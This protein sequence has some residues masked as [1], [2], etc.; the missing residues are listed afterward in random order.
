MGLGPDVILNRQQAERSSRTDFTDESRPNS[1]VARQT[2]VPNDSQMKAA[3]YRQYGGPEQIRVERVARPI[4]GEGEV[5]IRVA[6]SGFNVV[7]TLLRA[8]HMSGSFPQTFP[9][10]P[11]IELSGTVEALGTGVTKW[12]LGAQVYTSM[13]LTDSGGAA[14]FA[15]ARAE[16]LAAVPRS[17]DLADAGGVPLCA[18]TAWQLLFEH[19][20][21]ERGQRV[22]IVGASGS[23]GYYAVQLS[24]IADAYVV[25]TASPS[26]V[27]AVYGLG[28]DEV[29][30]YSKPNWTAES[31]APFDLIVNASPAQPEQVNSWL[32]L[33]RQGGTLVSAWSPVDEAEARRLHVNGKLVYMHNSTQQLTDIA[34]WIEDG[35]LRTKIDERAGL[36]QVAELHARSDAGK[37]R[38]K[39]LIVPAGLD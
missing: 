34:R 27:E 15:I 13:T 24:R 37:L 9:F 2:G 4:P 1:M 39:V 8:G 20:S 10:I 33:L 5:L 30:D 32:R 6:G 25:A 17:I 28:A 14:E 23:V 22:L 19:G 38:G 16:E 21:L 35:V 18:L 11:N 7:D 29:L 31:K 26:F 36:E 3:V 12:Q